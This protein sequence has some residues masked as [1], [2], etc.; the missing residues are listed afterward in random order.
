MPKRVLMVEGPDDE[1]VVKHICAQR[2]LGVIDKIQPYGGKD[3][4]IEGIKARLLESDIEAL[5]I[6]LDA[7]EDLQARWQAVASRLGVAG[8]AGVPPTPVAEGTVIPKPPNTLLPR[9]G[10]WLMPDNQVPGILENFL[11]FLIPAGDPLLAHADQAIA[12]MAPELC[13]FSV[14]RLP[15]ARIHTWLAWQAEPGKPLGQAISAR[16][17]DAELPTVDLF[18][19]WLRRTFFA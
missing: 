17:L 10:V 4:L 6:L 8:Y 14:A 9:V 15:K 11:R 2:Q 19:D 12:G 5:G 13:R 18:A 7:D 16:Y 3:R 1:H